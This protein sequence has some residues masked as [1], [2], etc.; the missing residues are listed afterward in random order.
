MRTRRE[1][2]IS[3]LRALL[4]VTLG[5]AAGLF[6]KQRDTQVFSATKLQ[7]TMQSLLGGVHAE[8]TS[9]VGLQAPSIAENGRRVK[10]SVR[11]EMPD[12]E[13]ISL[14][15]EKNLIPLT[16]QFIFGGRRVPFA[17][18]T[19]KVK[20]TS[21]IVAVVKTKVAFFKTSKKVR[22]VKGC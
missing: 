16:C 21:N 3:G 22:V 11:A 13:W 17:A 9:S 2:V 6:A 8:V 10:V 14:V 19:L 5:P 18:V 20:E 12:V 7:K 15:V 4:C 1:I